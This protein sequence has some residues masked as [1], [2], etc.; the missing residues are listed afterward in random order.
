MKKNFCIVGGTAS[1]AC[2]A[3]LTER[4]YQVIVLPE[5]SALPYPVS[6]HADMSVHIIGRSIFLYRDY[7]ETNRSLF[8]DLCDRASLSITICS[9]DFGAKYP[10]DIRLNFFKVGKYFVG[11]TD[12][13]ADELLKRAV[14]G[15]L[16]PL[17]CRQGYARCSACVVKNCVITQDKSL[18][19]V[20]Q[21]QHI[22]SL[23][24]E[25]GHVRLEGYGNGYEG[26]IGGASGYDEHIHTL[27]FTGKVSALPRYEKILS[28]CNLYDVNIVELTQDEL[29]DC[30]SLIFF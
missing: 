28:L 19:K 15:G 2:V 16:E 7:Y 18:Y 21:K 30:G 12:K 8:D 17:F 3:A 4:G 13:C 10:S 6:M 9:G 20:L 11:R 23:L 22:E 24:I 14:R 26:F 1:E 25:P 29:H 5:N 27:Y